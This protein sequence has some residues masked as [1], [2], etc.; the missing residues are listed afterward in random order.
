MGHRKYDGLCMPC[1]VQT[2]PD[3]KVARNY[4][5]KELCVKEFIQQVFPQFGWIFDKRFEDACSLR[6][7]DMR[8]DFGSHVL[9][10]EVDEHRHEGYSCD[11]KRDVQ[12]WQD[13]GERSIV[14]VRFNPDAYE[15]HTSCWATNK[16]GICV[17]K[18]TKKDEWT[19]RLAVLKDRIEHWS[20][21]VPTKMIER[22]ELFF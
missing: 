2:R 4:K 8:V 15:G 1:C 14:F 6:R 11:T 3:I 20:H 9:V 21:T 13:V 10:V 16:Q 22:D 5:T 19:A 18:H 7:P 12:L 17:V